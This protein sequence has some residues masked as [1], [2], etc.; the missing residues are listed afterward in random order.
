M[1][2]LVILVNWNVFILFPQE[3]RDQHRREIEENLRLQ[4]MEE[5]KLQD[6]KR[7]EE[8]KRK[9]MVSTYPGFYLLT[10]LCV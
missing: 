10:I 3:A 5:Q 9:E 7:Q 6:R 8:E 1:L 2:H 4:R